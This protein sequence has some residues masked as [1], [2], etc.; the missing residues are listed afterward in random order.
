[1]HHHVLALAILF[2]LC[3]CN[4]EAHK[5]YSQSP[6][7]APS[8]QSTSPNGTVAP[9]I[10]SPYLACVRTCRAEGIAVRVQCERN[11]LGHNDTSCI[12]L[13]EDWRR[14]CVSDRCSGLMP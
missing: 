12:S 7:S 13:G 2:T 1:M 3:A 9:A 11:P 10:P 14:E 4:D 8:G 5:R 6:A